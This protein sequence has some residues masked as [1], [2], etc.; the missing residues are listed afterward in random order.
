MVVQPSAP[1]V[2]EA[3]VW[4]GFRG[5]QRVGVARGGGGNRLGQVPSGAVVEAGRGSGLVLIRASRSSVRVSGAAREFFDARRAKPRYGQ[6][7]NRD[8]RLPRCCKTALVTTDRNARAWNHACI[9]AIGATDESILAVAA[10]GS[11]NSTVVALPVFLPDVTGSGRSG[12][13]MRQDCRLHQGPIEDYNRGL[14]WLVHA[15]RPR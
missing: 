6:S 4:P 11:S 15:R 2:V 12:A 1:P 9:R 8:R 5:V 13:C 14:G 3:A 7:P 10:H